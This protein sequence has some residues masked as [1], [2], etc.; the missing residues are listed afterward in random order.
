MSGARHGIGRR[1]SL[2]TLGALPIVGCAVGTGEPAAGPPPIT[3][4]AETRWRVVALQPE[5]D[6]AASWEVVEADL[7]IDAAGTNAFGSGGCN[8]WRAA[9]TSEAPGRIRFGNAASTMMAC[10]TPGFMERES[11]YLGSL[12][13]ISTY[14]LDG[15]ELTLEGDGRRITLR[16]APQ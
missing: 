14:S 2:L 8:R 4:L 13:A 10:V 5:P 7:T 9:V 16:A 15:D 1:R 6:A 12:A 3:A 11:A